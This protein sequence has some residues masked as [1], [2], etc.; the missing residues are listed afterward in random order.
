V[1]PKQIILTRNP[2][3]GDKNEHSKAG[4]IHNR[5]LNNLRPNNRG[6]WNINHSYNPNMVRRLARRQ[7][8]PLAHPR[9]FH[10]DQ[11]CPLLFQLHHLEILK[12]HTKK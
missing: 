3:A 5:S 10:N 1:K 2:E 11:F 4:P 7:K 8:H 6:I 9:H 12:M